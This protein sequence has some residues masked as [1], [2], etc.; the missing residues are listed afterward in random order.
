VA[1]NDLV[2]FQEKNRT[3]G[4]S[5]GVRTQID[6]AAMSAGSV[7]VLEMQREMKRTYLTEQHPEMLAL[8]KQ[9]YEL[10][11]ALSHSLYGEP[12]DLPPESSK[13]P[14]RKEFF[15]PAA[16]ITPL[17]FK[18]AEVYRD[19]KLKEA[20]YNFLVQ[21]IETFRYVKDPPLKP[22]DWLDRALPPG[23]P[24]GG[25]ILNKLLAAV[26]GSLAL[27]IVLALFL[28][29][30][31]RVKSEERLQTSEPRMGRRLVPAPEFGNGPLTAELLNGP[32]SSGDSPEEPAV[33]FP[34][35]RRSPV[36]SAV[37]E[38]EGRRFL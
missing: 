32:V 25:K 11:R 5:P 33:Y 13:A 22:L 23:G 21:N 19:F 24:I 36:E 6:A 7:L 30:L 28:E 37:R 35:R 8:S 2:Q 10:K 18:M 1:Q 31:E 15:V 16:K 27:G 4:L 12:Q 9:I 38:T 29:Y 20:V 14:P 17:Y 26:V 34:E 3:L